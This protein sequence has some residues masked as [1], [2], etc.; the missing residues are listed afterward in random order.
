MATKV[1]LEDHLEFHKAVSDATFDYKEHTFDLTDIC[2]TAKPYMFE[3]FR[4]TVL[5]SSC[6]LAPRPRAPRA[7]GTSPPPMKR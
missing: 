7:R 1:F 5:V 6:I 2:Y 4:F 3:C